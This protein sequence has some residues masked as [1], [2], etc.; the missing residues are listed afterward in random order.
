MNEMDKIYRASLIAGLKLFGYR[1]P[2]YERKDHIAN[3]AKKWKIDLE[4]YK[5]EFGSGLIWAEDRVVIIQTLASRKRELEES[6]GEE[7]NGEM[8]DFEYAFNPGLY[9]MPI[10]G[11]TDKNFYKDREELLRFAPDGKLYTYC[12][13]SNAIYEI[14]MWLP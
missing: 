7:W 2:Q 14:R 13:E 4:K 12:A 6:E 5:T 11:V 9:R 8:G 10:C 1:K 3:A